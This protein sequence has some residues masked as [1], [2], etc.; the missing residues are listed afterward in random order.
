[1]I[2]AQTNVDFGKQEKYKQEIREKLQLDLSMPDYSTGRIDAKVMGPRLAKILKS[3]CDNYR[4]YTN[5]SALSVIQ[6]NLVEGLSCGRIKKMKMDNESKLGH[7]IIIR[8]NTTLESNNLNLKKSQI[9]F[10]F[11]EGVS[12]DIASNDFFSYICRYIKE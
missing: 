10:Q 7:E 11:N 8:F 5:L 9:V 3:I 1:M 2:S 4:Q 12:D 6:S